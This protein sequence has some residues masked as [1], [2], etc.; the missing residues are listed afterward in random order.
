MFETGSCKSLLEHIALYEALESSMELA[1]RDE[2]LAEKD[3]S[4]PL[5]SAWK[6]SDTRD[7]PLS[8]SKQQSS[9]H[10]EQPVDD[11]PIQDSDNISDSEDTD[12][13]HLPK[14]KQRPEWLK[15]ILDDERP[16][17][18]ETA[19]VIPT[20]HILDAMTN[21]ANAL[22]TTYKALAEN[23]LLEKTGDMRTFMNWYFQKMGKTELTQEDFEGQAYEV[24]KPFYPNVVHLQFW[25][26]ECHKMLTDQID[27]ANPE[28]DQIRIDIIKP[29]PLSGP[30]GKL[31]D[32]NVHTLEDPTL[33]QEILSRRF[34]LRLNLPDNRKFLRALNLKW[35]AKVMAIEESKYLTSLSLDELIGN[36]NV[37][38]MIIKKY[39]EIVKA[40][41][42]RKSLSLKARKE[43]MFDFR[44]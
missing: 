4:S 13:A 11:I 5:S 7:A 28:G 17:T 26:E 6:K 23:S 25:M 8:S 12:S 37:Y 27:W 21:W 15:H 42:E 39:S 35:R 36:L 24:I 14:T 20:S 32:S 30:L 1:Q 2:F 9:P 22:A 16:A 34:F 40:K 38:E 31:G 41:R 29:L 10:A 3:K 33:I 44:K 43:S 18:P 19:C